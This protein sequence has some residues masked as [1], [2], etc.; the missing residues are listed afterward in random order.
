MWGREHDVSPPSTHVY[1]R[2]PSPFFVTYAHGEVDYCEED[3]IW[4]HIDCDMAYN[5][6]VSSRCRDCVKCVIK[7]RHCLPVD[8]SPAV[9][10]YA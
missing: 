10:R 3:L 6:T 9:Q 5:A 7:P 8:N 4:Q 1:E 2:H